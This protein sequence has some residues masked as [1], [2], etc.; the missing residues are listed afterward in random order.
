MIAPL[1]LATSIGTLILFDMQQ[2]LS[3][4]LTCLS[5]EWSYMKGG[6]SSEIK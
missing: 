3:K 6:P 1:K 2:K 5:E 4:N